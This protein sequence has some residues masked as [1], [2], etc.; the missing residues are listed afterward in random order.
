MIVFQ[1]FPKFLNAT[2]F[3]KKCI[4]CGNLFV[5]RKNVHLEMSTG[6]KLMEKIITKLSR[7]HFTL[8]NFDVFLTPH[9][10]IITCHI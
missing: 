1:K 10:V 3:S 8:A 7:P 6:I 4:P 5:N 2:R 9:P